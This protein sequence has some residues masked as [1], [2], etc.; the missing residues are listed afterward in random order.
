LEN[1]DA[2]ENQPWELTEIV[3]TSSALAIPSTFPRRL[4]RG[5]PFS[6]LSFAAM[7]SLERRRLIAPSLAFVL[8]GTHSF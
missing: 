2:P 7:V 8:A 3:A 5:I 6:P 1:S 4:R